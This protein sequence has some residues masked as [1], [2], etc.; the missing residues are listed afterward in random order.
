[1]AWGRETL[2]KRTEVTDFRLD[3]WVK[4]EADLCRI[5]G[6]FWRSFCVMS[7]LDVKNGSA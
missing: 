1:M 2:L 7:L 3:F 5:E 4:V 6:G